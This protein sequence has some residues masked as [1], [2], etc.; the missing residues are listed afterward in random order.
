MHRLALESNTP[1]GGRFLCV[2]ACL[3]M[4]DIA[5]AVRSQLSTAA[6]KVPSRELPDRMVKLVALFDPTVRT[7]VSEL[8]REVRADN[9][10]TRDALQTVCLSFDKVR[11]SRGGPGL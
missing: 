8:G 5:N 1:S 11:S 6:R 7:I 10:L 3:W 9:I 2:A 4:V